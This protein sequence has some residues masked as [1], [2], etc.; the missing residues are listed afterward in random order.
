MQVK[1][2]RYYE[3]E[4]MPSNGIDLIRKCLKRSVLKACID[5]SLSLI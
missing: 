2:V 4:Q 5:L 1:T 3:V